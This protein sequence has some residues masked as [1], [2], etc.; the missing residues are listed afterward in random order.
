MGEVAMHKKWKVALG[1]AAAAAGGLV[2]AA[3]VHR[4]RF[5]RRIDTEIRALLSKAAPPAAAEIEEADLEAL[6]EPV[7]RYLRF[8]GVVGRRPIRQVQLVQSGAFR[9][10]PDQD[11]RALSATEYYT[12]YPPAFIWSADI[13]AAPM[14]S[15]K[16]RDCYLDG[17]GAILG[18]LGG[19]LTVVDESGPGIDQGAALRFLN[20]MVFFPTAFLA[21]YVRWEPIDERSA[22][23]FLKHPNGEV[24]AIC[25]FAEDGRMTNF[26]A[27]RYYMGADDAAG[28]LAE[29]QTPF[30]EYARVD[31]FRIPAEG[32]GLWRL[33]AGDFEYIHLQIDAIA[34][35]EDID[36]PPL[37]E[38]HD[39]LQLVSVTS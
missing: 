9:L 13:A 11:W 1:V 7:Q 24:S 23:V 20:E 17:Y 37:L 12:S 6:P 35:D 28:R 4:R 16:V 30:G 14:L 33:E 34:Y 25:E 3:I 39:Q 29:W 18:K 5:L 38:G 27:L 26:I 10:G 36:T 15:F 31:G 22:R 8:A 21:D 2:G 32:A 19:A